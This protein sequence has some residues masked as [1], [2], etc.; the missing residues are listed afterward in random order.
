ML[1]G[2]SIPATIHAVTPAQ[3][4]LLAAVLGP[5]FAA[6]PGVATPYTLPKLAV[7]SLGLAAASLGA[8]RRLSEGGRGSGAGPDILRPLAACILV[9]GLSC[10]FSEN[11]LIS[12]LGEYEQ[13]GFGLLTLSLCA[14]A[15]VFVQEAGPVFAAFALTGG[16][17]AGA[18][19]SAFGLL[20]LFGLDPVLNAVGGLAY[21][22]IGSLVG[23]PIALGCVL[24]MLAP[25]QL[26]LA[27]DGETPG[28]RR[29]GWAFMAV[30]ALGLLFTW[31]RGAWAASAAGAACYLAWTGRLRRPGT[32]RAWLF[33]AGAAVLCAAALAVAAGR[34]RPTGRSDAGRTA[35]W[36]AAWRMFKARPVLGVGPDAFG[37]MLGRC[38]TEGF[39]RAYG[40]A[41]TQAHAHN[42]VLQ[43]LSAAGLA[44]L[45]AYLW[46]LT[47]AW[48]RLGAALRDGALRCGS[49]A[50]GAGLVAAF[51][52]AKFNPVNID[53][54]ALSAL[55]LGL[56]DPRGTRPRAFSRAA[57]VLCALAAGAAAWLTAADRMCMRGMRAQHDGRLSEARSAYSAAARTNPAEARYGYWLVGL[58]RESVRT[59]KDPARRLAL[60]AEA[61]A[62]ARVMERWNPSDVRALHA[63]GGSLAAYTLQGGPDSMAEAAA[64]LDRGPGADWSYRS[65][66]ETRLVVANLRGDA[67]AKEDSA[68]RLARLDSLRR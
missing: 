30:S 24:S 48:R 29:A 15:A 28:R 60:A 10:V 22:R 51:V 23:S 1:P 8:P 21:G 50:A 55:L 4:A 16:A 27:L 9:L 39:V 66:L 35:V 2:L 49:A 33:A 61:V 14:A 36:E 12:L 7:L 38:K 26:R 56:L 18:A 19:L 6:W 41:G 11:W 25:L 42:D 53:G 54:L 44:G 17:A 43:A 62:A 5:L 58:L 52:V 68:A 59:E 31:S 34:F 20:Q 67:R 57:P 63:L 13:R 40:E 64:V 65:L 47:A 46:L 37:L 45:G 3:W 32:R